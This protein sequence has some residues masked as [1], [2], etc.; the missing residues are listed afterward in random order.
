MAN[1]SE[2]PIELDVGDNQETE[3]EVVSEVSSSEDDDRDD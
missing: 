2:N 3:V 1:S